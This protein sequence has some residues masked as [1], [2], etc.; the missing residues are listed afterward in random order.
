MSIC[1]LV[2][3]LHLDDYVCLLCLNCFLIGKIPVI[4]TKTIL[5]C[6]NSSHYWIK[7]N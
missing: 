3:K 1:C 5:N 4:I 2:I 6:N 7:D